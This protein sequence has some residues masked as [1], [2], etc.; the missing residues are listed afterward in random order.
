VDF[1]RFW[2]I[3]VD[4]GSILN[5][6]GGLS[7]ARFWGEFSHHPSIMSLLFFPRGLDEIGFEVL[8]EPRESA[9]HGSLMPSGNTD[10]HAT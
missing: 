6:L 7:F 10:I 3:L 5:P 8:G 4:L 1:G 2:S 9:G